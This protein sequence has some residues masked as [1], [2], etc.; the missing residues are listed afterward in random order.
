MPRVRQ[1]LTPEITLKVTLEG[2]LTRVQDRFSLYLPQIRRETATVA[3]VRTPPVRFSLS[4][5]S[6][7]LTISR[8]G[9]RIA[10][11]HSTNN[12]RNLNQS[13]ASPYYVAIGIFEELILRWQN[14][15]YK[16]LGRQVKPRRKIHPRIPILALYHN[17]NP[18]RGLVF[19]ADQFQNRIARPFHEN[20]RRAYQTNTF[21]QTYT[22]TTRENK[23]HGRN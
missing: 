11:S 1:E 23:A 20:P 7:G 10:G 15:I 8:T 9:T 22:R 4:Y 19:S 12:L 14:T 13:R 17:P 3:Q 2:Y 6:L 5:L 21:T 16:S 18:R